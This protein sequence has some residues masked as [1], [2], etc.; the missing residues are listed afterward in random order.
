M[1]ITRH[2]VYKTFAVKQNIHTNIIQSAPYPKAN[3]SRNFV[4]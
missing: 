3:F 1:Q 4:H 2:Y